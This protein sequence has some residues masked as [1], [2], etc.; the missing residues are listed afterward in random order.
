MATPNKL[1]QGTQYWAAVLSKNWGVKAKLTRLDGEYDLNFLAISASKK[2]LIFKV[3]RENCPEWLVK[4][5][6]SAMQHIEKIANL[7]TTPR[8]FL[9]LNGQSCIEVADKT[10]NL[11]YLWTLEYIPGKCLA[12]LRSKPP[13]LIK[14][15]GVALGLSLIHI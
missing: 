7:P 9:S 14:E 15:I 5:Q 13:S 8:V 3:M 10:G 12:K 2:P 1:D 6:I 4:S 11:R